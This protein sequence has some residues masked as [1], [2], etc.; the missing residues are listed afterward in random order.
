M[1]APN[2]DTRL[3]RGD[4]D[5]GFGSGAGQFDFTGE[6]PI[7][8]F[9]A[10]GPWTFQFYDSWGGP[11]PAHTYLPGSLIRLQGVSTLARLDLTL[12]T[13]SA[14]LTRFQPMTEI[15]A[16]PV[17]GAAPYSF[18]I[19]PPLPAG[20]TIDP[21]TGTISGTP[22]ETAPAQDYTVT[23]TDATGASE[24]ASVNI[25]VDVATGWT[26]NWTTTL[27]RGQEVIAA[28]I[29]ATGGG[30]VAFSISPDLP[31]RSGARRHST[32]RGPDR[33]HTDRV[34]GI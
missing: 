27:I 31:P 7:G 1:I 11:D 8:P 3:F 6:I 10:E 23:V 9:D 32:R 33:R 17:G 25:T 12:S 34:A 19:D 2:G 26:V 5:F 24:T 13:G 29:T 16:T 18:E 21:D 22:T 4:N 30:G 14:I 20:L 15:T 28:T